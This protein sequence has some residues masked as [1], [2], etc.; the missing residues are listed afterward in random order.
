MATT[1]EPEVG[2]RQWVGKSIRRVEDRKFLIGRGN[3]V[4]DMAMHGMLHAALVRSPHAHAR[5]VS[6]DTSAA[7]ALPGVHAVVTGA[8]AA[9]LC[10]PLPDFG[11]DPSRHGWRCLAHEKVRYAGEGVAAVVADSRYVAEDAAALVR[12]E[13][14][15][16]PAV[17]EMEEAMTSDS[18]VHEALGSNLVF[19]RKLSWGGDVDEAFANAAHV[20]EDRLQW[21]RSGAQP[22]ETV[23]SI[24]SFEP[25]TGMMT[26]ES[27]SVSLSNYLFL[28]AGTLKLP[29][30]KLDMRPHPAGGSF[31]SK[32]WAVKVSVV[33][34]ML[35]RL[36][37]RPV[38]LV[39]DRVD[40]M[41]GCDHHG[42]SRIY[43]TQLAVSADGIFESL[44][45]RVVD[46]YGAYF[47]F[48][49]GQHGNALAQTVGPY[50]IR[51]VEYHVQAVLTNKCQQGAYR[52]FGSEVGNWMLERLVDLAAQRLGLDP[53][54]IRRR[55]F[56]APESF[57]YY[58]PGGNCYDS[59]NYEGV[60]DTALELAGYEGLIA[61]RDRLR[62]EGRH[63]GVGICTAQER[64]VYGSTEW[65]FWF[66][67][68]GAAVTS[69]PESIKLDIDATGGVTA[70]LYSGASWGNSAETMVAQFV[71]EELGVDPYAISIVYSGSNQGLPGSGPGGSRFTVMIA[72]AIRGASQ[73]IREKAIRVAAHMLEAAPEDL[74]WAD[75]GVRVKGSPASRAE[76]GDIAA[77][78]QM[79]KHSLPDDLTTGLDASEVYDHP[80]TTLPN[81]DRSELG[82]FYP[83]MGHACHIAMVEVDPETGKVDFLR[84]AAVHDCGTLVNPRTLAGHITGGTAQGIGTALTEE[85]V[86]DP[87]DGALLASDYWDYPIPTAMDVPELA[88]G[89]QETPSPFTPHGIKGGGE[90]GRMMAPAVIS[91]A[92]DDALSDYGVRVR[93]LPATPERIL[94][95]IDEGRAAGG[96]A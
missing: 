75:G 57:P 86:Y 70:T 10:D 25:G 36:V 11:L 90:G 4:D 72:G 15:P 29:A 44:R 89:H 42:S 46:D 1:Q 13:Y 43:Y 59:G 61:E 14:E 67:E 34:G 91:S 69:V 40:N 73:Q 5:I 30:N 64:S 81:A 55:N 94:A 49:V 48:G 32:F 19:E 65:W 53:V 83:M 66:D 76:L 6:I 77:T 7:E 2:E 18:L 23:G 58:I 85:Y 22:L 41:A 74:E 95:W 37:G 71:A 93:R 38:K 60:L 20:I 62:A 82:V 78:V 96:A 63:V 56:I 39:E 28:L 17:V 35:S 51:S 47:Q 3:F 54:E 21:G 26:I 24:A 16:L 84:Y 87:Q 80:Y 31:G 9:E 27:N 92:I 12:V 68:P 52:G 45:F 50:R 88:I 33:A 8:Q 79:F